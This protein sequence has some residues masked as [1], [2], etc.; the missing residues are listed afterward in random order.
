MR[1]R[2]ADAEPDGVDHHP[3]RDSYN[4]LQWEVSNYFLGLNI[5]VQDDQE[6]QAL[7][8]R[9]QNFQQGR[10]TF[11]VATGDQEAIYGWISAN[12]SMGRLENVNPTYGFLEMGGQSV[13]IAYKPPDHFNG[14]YTR[15]TIRWDITKESHVFTKM[16]SGLGTKDARTKYLETPLPQVDEISYDRC[17]IEGEPIPGGL[18]S[19]LCLHPDTLLAG[20]RTLPQQIEQLDASLVPFNALLTAAVHLD[21]AAAAVPI[22]L[23]G[24]PAIPVEP[25]RFVGGSSFWYANKSLYPPNIRPEHTFDFAE[26]N[27]MICE[28]AAVNWNTH[29]QR[30]RAQAEE[31]VNGM[32]DDVVHELMNGENIADERVDLTTQQA[33]TLEGFR[34]NS[35]FC[36]MLVH[37]TLYEGIGLHPDARFQ[38]FD[39]VVGLHAGDL[40]KNVPYSWTL[41]KALIEATG[42]NEPRLVSSHLLISLSLFVHPLLTATRI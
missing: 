35:L 13:Q 16:I 42:S 30:V 9:P 33:D 31:I 39:G 25:T 5:L 2:L 32:D 3:L 21:A 34:K 14:P 23:H 26:L 6:D 11:A 41:G 20:A 4:A 22:L 10:R 8:F 15:V 19:G 7:A 36:A 27:R 40:T 12:Y 29:R 28:Y 17:A 37:S 24:A 38:P 1:G 18:G